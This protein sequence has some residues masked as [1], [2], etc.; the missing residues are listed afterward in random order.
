METTA[1]T[2]TTTELKQN[3]IIKIPNQYER[4]DIL[5]EIPSSGMEVCM[6]KQRRK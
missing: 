2:E 5:K 3:E 1:T 4:S 6:E